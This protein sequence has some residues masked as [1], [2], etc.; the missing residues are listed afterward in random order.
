LLGGVLE[1][2]LVEEPVRALVPLLNRAHALVNGLFLKI[3]PLIR[4][5]TLHTALDP[6]LQRGAHSVAVVK[7]EVVFNKMG[8]QTEC[9]KA[10]QDIQ[11]VHFGG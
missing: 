1:L 3:A 8:D 4:G 9:E 2:G 6:I 10:E 11:E 5:K 7:A